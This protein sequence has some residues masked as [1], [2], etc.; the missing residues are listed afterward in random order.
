MGVMFVL[1]GAR[2]PEL[3]ADNMGA[4]AGLGVTT[5]SV[6]SEGHLRG[7]VLQ[8]WAFDPRESVAEVREIL[9]EGFNF[10][11]P[12]LQFAVQGRGKEER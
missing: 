12:E 6:V 2:D 9:G 10:L 7:I 1:T 11:L 8:G 4:L 3:G 5:V